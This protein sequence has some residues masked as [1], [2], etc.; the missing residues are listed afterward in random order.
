MSFPSDDNSTA[1]DERIQYLFNVKHIG[2]PSGSFRSIQKYAEKLYDFK[3]EH[4]IQRPVK[5][6]KEENPSCCIDRLITV[7]V[8]ET[9]SVRW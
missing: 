3:R 9:N 2:Y 6:N 8:V 7:V 5:K 1:V 4:C